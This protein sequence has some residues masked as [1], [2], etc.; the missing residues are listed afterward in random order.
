MSKF[1]FIAL[2]LALVC[3][4]AALGLSIVTLGQASAQ[5]ARIDELEAQNIQ[6]QSQ[7]NDLLH[8][9]DIAPAAGLNSWALT[10]T[11]WEDGTGA[12]ITLT[13]VP[14][15]YQEGMQAR[16]LVML[17]GTEVFEGPCTW[18]G[19]SFTATASIPA[20]DGYG[21]YFVQQGTALALTTPENPVEDI[22]VYLQ[23]SLRSFC[24]LLVD[25]WES[26]EDSLI[27]TSAHGQATLPRLSTGGSAPRI[28]SA[29]LVMRQEVE[30]IAR[31]SVELVPG[32]GESTYELTVSNAVFS[33]PALEEGDQVDIWLE[34]TLSDGQVL[35]S[36]TSGWYLSGN[37]L[38]LVAG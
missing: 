21:Y 30:E 17:E 29:A 4:V 5:A 24:T 35:L 3:A 13:A 27:I 33:L 2:I 11:A 19:T 12:D 22:P 14:T 7:I 25:G 32:E 9:G 23:S 28:V 10:P 31:H 16:F 1:K 38:K 20:A 8:T 37:E 18:N 15:N 6:L 36:P 34:V 26:A